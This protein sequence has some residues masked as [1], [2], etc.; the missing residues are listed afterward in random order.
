M[1]SYNLSFYVGSDKMLLYTIQ[2]ICSRITFRFMWFHIK[3]IAVQ[4][5]A[6]AQPAPVVQAASA[7]EAITAVEEDNTILEDFLG[8]VDEEEC[9]EEEDAIQAPAEDEE[10]Y[11]EEEEEEEHDDDEYEDDDEEEEQEEVGGGRAAPP[12]AAAASSIV[13]AVG[14]HIQQRNHVNANFEGS[15]S[16]LAI[17]YDPLL[18]TFSK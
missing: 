6:S 13:P 10:E 15:S 2:L 8:E 14:N 7:V 9:K 17:L 3:G 12:I 11:K 4:A 16:Y 18:G 5:P 1:I